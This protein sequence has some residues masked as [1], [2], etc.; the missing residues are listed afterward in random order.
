MTMQ[1]LRRKRDWQCVGEDLLN[2]VSI[3]GCQC[4]RCGETMMLLMNEF[5]EVRNMQQAMTVVEQCLAHQKAENEISSQFE[6][7]W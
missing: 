7:W 5:V 2:W 3:L 4:D 6:G 1:D